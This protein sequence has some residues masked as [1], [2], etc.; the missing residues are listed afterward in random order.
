MIKWLLSKLQA[1]RRP[2]IS[3][4]NEKLLATKRGLPKPNKKIHKYGFHNE[5]ISV[6]WRDEK[7][8]VKYKLK[9]FRHDSF[10]DSPD[11]YIIA[12]FI[13]AFPE[14]CKINI[15]DDT[16]EVTKLGDTEKTASPNNYQA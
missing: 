3:E 4:E 5:I 12:R 1:N 15:G 11:F 10:L 9:P 6:T 8:P 16:Y 7:C 13:A 14:G 2:K